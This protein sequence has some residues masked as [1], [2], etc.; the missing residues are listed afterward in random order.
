MEAVARWEG[1]PLGAVVDRSGVVPLTALTVLDSDEFNRV[2]GL[3][4]EVP[5]T[6][7]AIET[8]RAFYQGLGQAAF[9]VELSSVSAPGELSRWLEDAGLRRMPV[10]VTKLWER[11]RGA[12]GRVEVPCGVEVRRLVSADRDAAAKL[13]ALAY[14]AWDLQ[15]P[16]AP[17]FSAPV[18]HPGFIHYGAFAGQ[19]LV[20]IGAAFVESGVAWLGLAATHPRYRSQNI[21]QRLTAQRLAD[22]AHLGCELVHAEVRSDRMPSSRIRLF[23]HFYERPSFASG[24]PRG[25]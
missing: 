1:N 3:G 7:S 6:Q 20:S 4:V 2:F 24:T 14:G 18:G 13:Y 9:R 22:V 8:I 15:I 17:W 12:A 19:R 11:L 21:Q 23:E 10:T 16:L 25:G 5:A